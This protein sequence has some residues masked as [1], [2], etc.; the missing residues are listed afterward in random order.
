MDAF[1]TD[2]LIYASTRSHPLG[3]PVRALLSSASHR[4]VGS[5]LLLVESLIKPRREGSAKEVKEL[6]LMLSRLDLLPLTPTTCELAVSLGATYALKSVD[7]C[8]LATAVEAGADRFITNNHNDFPQTISE[9]EIT[10]PAD[11]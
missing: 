6:L 3:R 7:A 8:H 2:V 10:Y 1:D 5:V 11:L 4:R 9:I